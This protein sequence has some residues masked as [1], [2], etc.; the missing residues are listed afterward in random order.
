MEIGIKR[1]H[2]N[3]G[4]SSFLLIVKDSS[5]DLLSHSLLQLQGLVLYVLT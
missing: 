1:I 3:F 4:A 2:F 5:Q